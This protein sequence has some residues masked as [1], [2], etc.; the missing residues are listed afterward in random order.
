MGR[1]TTNIQSWALHHLLLLF[2]N[3]CLNGNSD[4]Q[5]SLKSLS[6]F[7][8]NQRTGTGG[9]KNHIGELRQGRQEEGAGSHY[10][11]FKVFIPSKGKQKCHTVPSVEKIWSPLN[12]KEK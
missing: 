3:F 7:H 2:P 8:Q 9:Q 1:K 5:L 10:C 12:S 6:V 11:A 4:I